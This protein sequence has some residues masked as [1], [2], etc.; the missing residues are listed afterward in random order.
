MASSCRRDCRCIQHETPP[1]QWAV[2]NPLSGAIHRSDVSQENEPGKGVYYNSH[3]RHH[4]AVATAGLHL[5]LLARSCAT[6]VAQH[7]VF[8]LQLMHGRSTGN[9]HSTQQRQWAASNRLDDPAPH[10]LD[11]FIRVERQPC[12]TPYLGR[13]NSGPRIPYTQ[14]GSQFYCRW[15]HAS[16]HLSQPCCTSLRAGHPCRTGC[17]ARP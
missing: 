11:R 13:L 8:I 4:R 7:S 15:Q 5:F 16:S 14:L 1:V 9:T 3:S 10:Q 2:T 17:A 12:R 6:H